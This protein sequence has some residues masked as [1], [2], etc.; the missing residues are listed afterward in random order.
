MI[1]GIYSTQ[2]FFSINEYKKISIYTDSREFQAYQNIELLFSKNDLI[3]M[4]N[5]KN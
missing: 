5:F 2:I 1:D 3:V 4:K